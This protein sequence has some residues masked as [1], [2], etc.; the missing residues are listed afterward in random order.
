MVK[1]NITIAG[2]IS[3]DMALQGLTILTK[4]FSEN[5]R[6]TQEEET[7]QVHIKAYKEREIK[8]VLA[9]QDVL[10][11]YLKNTFEERR[12]IIDNLFKNLDRGVKSKDQYLIAQSMGA[13]VSIVKESP[14]KNM[15]KLLDD[16]DDNSVD[17]ITI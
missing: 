5:H 13:I 17:S 3:W 6:V 2:R 16:F 1:K 12:V 14:L 15:K 7:K 4:S 11:Y 8:R 10:K 9:K